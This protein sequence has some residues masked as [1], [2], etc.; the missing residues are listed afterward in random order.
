PDLAGIDWL[1]NLLVISY[2]RGDGK[3]GLTYNYKLPEEPNDF[4]VADLNNDGF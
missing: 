1:N 3:F 4:M 2:G